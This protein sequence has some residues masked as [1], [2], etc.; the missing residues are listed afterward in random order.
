LL[1]MK[2]KNLISKYPSIEHTSQGREISYSSS[3]PHVGMLTVAHR[4]TSLR[5]SSGR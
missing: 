1:G 3:E 2:A 5:A 4:A